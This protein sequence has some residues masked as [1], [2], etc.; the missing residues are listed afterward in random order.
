MTRKERL[1]RTLNGQSVDRP[2]VSFYELN[3]LD[4]NPNDKNPFNIY[5]D[6]SWKPL[7]ELTREKTDRIVIRSVLFNSFLPDIISHFAEIEEIEKNGSI[8]TTK[9]IKIGNKVL[10]SKT[11]RDK[12]VNTI[13]T[14]EHLIKNED[15]LRTILMLPFEE[16][17]ATPDYE[18][19][20]KAEDQL[21]DTGI[22]MIDMPDPLCLAASLFSMDEY[23]IIALSEQELFKSLLDRFAFI[24]YN[25]TN[26]I[27]SNLPKR[28]WRI[29]GPEYASE[30]FLPPKLFKE[31]VVN[32]DR[33]MVDMIHKS[34]GWVRIHSHGNL[35][36]ILDLI[37]ELNA[38]AIDPI[39][40]PPQGDVYLKFVREKYGKNFVLFGNLE[41]TDIENL[42]PDEFSKKVYS[43]LEEGTSGEGKGFVLMP[44]SCP[45][46]RFLS[47]MTLRN[48]EII[49]EI[50]EKL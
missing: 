44:S 33:I 2:A 24:L 13:W 27:S 37:V 40:P 41:I 43:A 9:K 1:I 18:S 45:Y 30:P 8:F 42:L 47:P 21:G 3:G 36:N 7:I 16:F 19:V 50:I 26:A 48:Y 46:G 38:D 25:Y 49:I 12:D 22:V 35:R 14:E 34:G 23:T 15:D 17:S 4:E 32:Y 11:R 20:I 29:Y 39:E 10:Q 28:L 6:P 5:N 31:Y